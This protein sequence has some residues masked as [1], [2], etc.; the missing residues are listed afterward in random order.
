MLIYITVVRDVPIKQTRTYAYLLATH[1]LFIRSKAFENCLTIR[2]D[3]NKKVQLEALTVSCELT[4][5]HTDICLLA[6]EWILSLSIPLEADSVTF[7]MNDSSL[8]IFFICHRN[9]ASTHFCI[10][11]DAVVGVSAEVSKSLTE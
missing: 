8:R 6:R 2:S 1:E 3:Y 5:E 7:W 11:Q 4:A 9:A 10:W